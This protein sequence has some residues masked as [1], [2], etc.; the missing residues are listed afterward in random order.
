MLADYE[1]SHP[2]YVNATQ[3][4]LGIPSAQLASFAFPEVTTFIHPLKGTEALVSIEK[5]RA[6]IGFESEYKGAW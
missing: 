3:N 5:A 4:T 6:L 2:L 1:G